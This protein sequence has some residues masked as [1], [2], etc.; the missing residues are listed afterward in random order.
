MEIK[1]IKNIQKRLISNP[2]KSARDSNGILI[3]SELKINVVSPKIKIFAKL[4]PIT[5]PTT[6]SYFLYLNIANNDVNISGEEE[7]SA[8]YIE[9]IIAED[10]P[11]SWSSDPICTRNPD[12]SANSPAPDKIN[13][14]IFLLGTTATSFISG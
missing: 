5:L 14:N 2:D 1:Y 8:K 9:P 3:N 13:K 11:K 6:T 10:I 12:P 4:L 7:A